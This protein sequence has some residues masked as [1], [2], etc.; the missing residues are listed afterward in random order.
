MEAIS[1]SGFFKLLLVLFLSVP[2]SSKDA[3][4]GIA[5]ESLT[6]T[7]AVGAAVLDVAQLRAMIRED[8]ELAKALFDGR[9]PEA[10]YGEAIEAMSERTRLDPA[11][12]RDAVARVRTVGL[13][14]LGM[15]DR[16]RPRFVVVC[17]RGGAPDIL[18]RLL[19]NNPVAGASDAGPCRTVVYAGR[20]LHSVSRHPREALWLTEINGMLVLASD[21][22]AAET[23]L[24]Q[25]AAAAK[26]PPSARLDVSGTSR[27][28][29]Q[30][31]AD[32]GAVVNGLLPAMGDHDSAEFMAAGAFF[33]LPA[34]RGAALRVTRDAIVLRAEID[35][36]SPLAAALKPPERPPALLDAIPADASLALAVSVRDTAKVWDLLE[37]GFGHIAIFEH[38]GTGPR[39]EFIR[40]FRRETGLDVQADLVSNLVAAAVVVTDPARGLELDH[41]GALYFEGKDATSMLTS[42][43]VLMARVEKEG[44]AGKEELR[45]V[46]VWRTDEA[47]IALKG[48]VVLVAPSR[49]QTRAGA[50]RF[51]KHFIEG[52]DSIGKTLAAR[53]P[54]AMAFATLDAARCFPQSGLE[55]ITAGL[56]SDAAGVTL[57]VEGGSRNLAAGIVRLLAGAGRAAVAQ[58]TQNQTRNSL[59]QVAMACHTYAMEYQKL[60]AEIADLKRYVGDKDTALRDAR[61]GQFFRLNPAVT[62]RPLDSVKNPNETVL[63]YAPPGP[64]TQ[65]VCVAFCD[66]SVRILTPAQLETALKPVPQKD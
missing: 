59:R 10:A 40:D 52:G 21:T 30:M 27:P 39:E 53:Q 37:A 35:P 2:D 9:T 43:R 16:R 63:A 19:S 65:P 17:D 44:K 8:P 20:T 58:N 32:V 38:G 42:V 46:T 34:W 22:M 28:L 7:V 12:L 51:L 3:D 64:D 6:P 31:R 56:T 25:A 33:D 60:P 47:L 18:P 15:A 24:L 66:G 49:G 48:T 45:G 55:R 41:G 5:L 54:G 11:A 1:V 36:G 23:F 62:G 13:W 61:S 57:R 50:E 29:L 4:R 14:P 26:T